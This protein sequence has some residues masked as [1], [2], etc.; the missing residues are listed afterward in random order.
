M[1]ALRGVPEPASGSSVCV[2]RI[3]LRLRFHSPCQLKAC[4]LPAHACSSKNCGCVREPF[5]QCYPTAVSC[6]VCRRA[7]AWERMSVES[8]RL[9]STQDVSGTGPWS[10]TRHFVDV[11]TPAKQLMGNARSS[12]LFRSVFCNEALAQ[13][14]VAVFGAVVAP[15]LHRP[16]HNRPGPLNNRGTANVSCPQ[17]KIEDWDLLGRSWVQKLSQHSPWKQLVDYASCPYI[18]SIECTLAFYTCEGDGQCRARGAEQARGGRIFL[19]NH[20]TS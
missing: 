1:C 16:L 13:R 3:L 4:L 15:V 7:D 10:G 20:G 17:Q 12:H 18:P 14:P 6:P 19:K 9:R 5:V 8:A 2:R 11:G